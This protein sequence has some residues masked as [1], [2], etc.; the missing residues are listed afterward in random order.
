MLVVDFDLAEPD[1][2]EEGDLAVGFDTELFTAL[3]GEL[4]RV[5]VLRLALDAPADLLAVAISFTSCC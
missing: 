3:L 2:P 1:V 5:G 4:D